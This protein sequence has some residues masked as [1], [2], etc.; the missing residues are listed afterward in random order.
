M[1]ET[2]PVGDRADG[3]VSHIPLPMMRLMSVGMKPINPAMADLI[4]AA[5]VMDTRDMTFDQSETSRRYPSIPPSSLA[6][7]IRE[8]Y[9]RRDDPG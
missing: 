7:V 9:P 2:V 4:Q 6:D 8:D 5:V 1:V 3:K